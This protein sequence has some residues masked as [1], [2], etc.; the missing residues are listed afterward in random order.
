MPVR[1]VIDLIDRVSGEKISHLGKTKVLSPE[2]DSSRGIKGGPGLQLVTGASNNT[3]LPMSSRARD[4]TLIHDFSVHPVTDM[5]CS[6]VRFPLSVNQSL[7]LVHLQPAVRFV[8]SLTPSCG[9][10]S[11]GQDSQSG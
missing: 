1:N 4:A 11:P 9:A 8:Q 10:L 7:L 5:L 3:A 2:L 6:C